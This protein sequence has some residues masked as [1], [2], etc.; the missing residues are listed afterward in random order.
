MFFN[1]SKTTQKTTRCKTCENNYSETTSKLFPNYANLQQIILNYS[2]ATRC[3]THVNK[4]LQNYST[5]TRYQTL[6][7]TK[8]TPKLLQH[9]S[10]TT[11]K[12]FPYAYRNFEKLSETTHVVCR[13]GEPSEKLLTWSGG[14]GNLPKNI[15]TLIK[16]YSV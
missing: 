15:P 10:K 6:K 11:P 4:L 5:N 9:D 2:K 1:Y 8:T 14:P 13:S 12:L 7:Y 16:N 3:K